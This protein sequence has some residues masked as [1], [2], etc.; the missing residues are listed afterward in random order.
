MTGASSWGW[1][2]EAKRHIKGATT[3]P[4]Q[5]VFKVTINSART[6][7][8]RGGDFADGVTMARHQGAASHGRVPG[9]ALEPPFVPCCTAD[10]PHEATLWSPVEKRPYCVICWNLGANHLSHGARLNPNATNRR[11]QPNELNN[12]SLGDDRSTA[13]TLNSTAGGGFQSS[14]ARA[15]TPSRGAASQRPRTPSS[16]FDDA[17]SNRPKSPFERPVS[18]KRLYLGRSFISDGSFAHFAQSATKLRQIGSAVTIKG[19]RSGAAL[20][21]VRPHSTKDMRL[22]A[23]HQPVKIINGGQNLESSYKPAEFSFAAQGYS[24]LIEVPTA[25]KLPKQKVVGT[26]AGHSVVVNSNP[27]HG[28]R[29]AT[30]H[31]QSTVA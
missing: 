13:G 24:K 16:P 21:R 9:H 7:L 25:V 22:H 15:Q 17:F 4:S 29:S 6:N 20:H 12:D 26:F 10:C 1:P 14:T 30:P 18:P 31:V 8:Q 23:N 11:P 3:N 19:A 5:P 28:A 27:P 2:P